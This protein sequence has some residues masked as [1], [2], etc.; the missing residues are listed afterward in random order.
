M[1]LLAKSITRSALNV[2]VHRKPQIKRSKT[3]A[4]KR[5]DT[6]AR[7]TKVFKFDHEGVCVA[8]EVVKP[9]AKR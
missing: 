6:K 7:A 9:H 3:F 2:Q 8:I 1:S 5:T 4:C